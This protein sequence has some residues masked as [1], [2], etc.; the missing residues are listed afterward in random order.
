[1]CILRK[2]YIKKYRICYEYVRK[3][4]AIDYAI[5]K[6]K[7]FKVLIK[8]LKQISKIETVNLSPKIIQ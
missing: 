4:H 6:E 7:V 5:K 1:M 3:E 8:N 2:D